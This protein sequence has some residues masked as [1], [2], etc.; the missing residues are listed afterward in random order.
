MFVSC[1]DQLE[2]HACFRLV[3]GDVG[4]IIKDEQVV[5]VELVDGGFKLQLPSG[6]LEVVHEIGGPGE[7]DPPSVLDQGQADS[8]SEMALSS[9]GRTE[10]EDI[11][12]FGKPTVAGG[13][14]HDLCLGDHRHGIESE[15]VQCLAGRQV[16][17]GEMPLNPAMG[18]FRQ[19]VLGNRR[20]EASG[21]PSFPVRLFGKSLP[22]GFDRGH[23]DFGL[24]GHRFR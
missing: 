16:R 24:T 23:A 3:L 8:G 18:P 9:A 2:E 19:F 17:F 15:A 10:H 6:D 11:G 7:Q 21:R 22:Q 14:C 4:K 13:D 5:L 1:R 20:Q 12:F